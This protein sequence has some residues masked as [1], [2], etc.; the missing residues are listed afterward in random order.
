M[1]LVG[2]RGVADGKLLARFRSAISRVSAGIAR[3]KSRLATFGERDA[4]EPAGGRSL[5]DFVLE[6]GISP[7]EYVVNLLEERGGDLHQQEII[8]EAG[9]NRSSVSR[10]L[11]EMEENGQIRRVR[12]GTENEVYLPDAVPDLARP[13]DAASTADI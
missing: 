3:T 13:S 5:A 8:A 10:L 6:T 4:S 12:L 7:D 11:R 1:R 2:R 9:L